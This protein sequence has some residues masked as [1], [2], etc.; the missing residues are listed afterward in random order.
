MLVS[1]RAWKE[2]KM[3]TYPT[4]QRDQGERSSGRRLGSEMTENR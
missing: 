3:G 4:C 2:E 1:E